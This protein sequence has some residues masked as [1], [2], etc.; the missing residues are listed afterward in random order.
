MYVC[1]SVYVCTSQR[2]WEGAQSR[3]WGTRASASAATFALKA[4]SPMAVC[5]QQGRCLSCPRTPD[6]S[7][8]VRN[9]EHL[10]PGL[11]PIHVGDPRGLG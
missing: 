8:S 2:A 6:L 10:F 9:T 1:E 4:P 7:P 11:G 5:C 3:E